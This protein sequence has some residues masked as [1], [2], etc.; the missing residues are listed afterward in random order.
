MSTMIRFSSIQAWASTIGGFSPI[1]ERGSRPSSASVA[2]KIPPGRPRVMTR[3][4]D[5]PPPLPLGSQ[6]SPAVA[7]AGAARG[8]AR[9]SAA[10]RQGRRESLMP[11]C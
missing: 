5:G 11:P 8:A 10:A 3:L 7:C 4:S 1:V 9:V 2:P 6:N